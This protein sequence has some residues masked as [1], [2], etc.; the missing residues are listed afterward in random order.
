MISHLIVNAT[1]PGDNFAS[2]ALRLRATYKAGGKTEE[3]EKVTQSFIVKVEPYKEGIQKDMLIDTQLFNVEI[4]MYSQVI[5]EM[6]RLIMEVDP[7][8]VLAPK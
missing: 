2:I 7:K 3:E 6:Q 8:E 5:P 4:S 1:K